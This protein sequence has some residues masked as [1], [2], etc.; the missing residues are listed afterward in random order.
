[1]SWKTTLYEYVHYKNQ[2][3][4]DYT[5]V[6][7]L[8]FV[9]DTQYLQAQIKRLARAS[10]TDQDRQFF[11]VKHEARLTIVQASEQP[12]AVTAAVR[13]RQ[14]AVGMI[15]L[16]EHQEERVEW[17]RIT[18]Q[19]QGGRWVI[20]QIQVTGHEG[21]HPDHIRVDTQLPDKVRI[22]EYG[23]SGEDDLFVKLPSMP[24]LN[25][26]VLPYLDRSPRQF[27]Y[28]RN[29]SI[30]YAELWWDKANP[31][32]IEF[33]VDCTNFVSQCLF[34]GGAPMH[35]TGKRDSGW[36]YRGRHNGQEHW[37]FSWAV[38]QSLQAYMMNNHSGWQVEE[39]ETADLLEL[40]D[41][42]SY[43]WKGDGRFRHSAVVT[44]KDAN[45]MPLVNAH[46]TNS[47]HRYWSYRDSYAWTEKTRY[48]F[49]HVI[50]AP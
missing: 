14:V 31:A 37:S 1:M 28:D 34:A 49:L 24:F 40:G 47:R 26:E 42:I 17:E 2:M 45:G 18:L 8:P 19:E 5:V 35:Y 48:S 41:V 9:T 20:T 25:Y 39:A 36:W 32:Y 46:T 44:A 6:P 16:A 11:P 29:K 23:N 43:D 10:Q 21:D 50:D 33:E 3:N 12:R 27:K 30:Q 15:G 4:L 13:L 38:A 22:S 7:L